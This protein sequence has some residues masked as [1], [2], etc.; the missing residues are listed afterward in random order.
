MKRQEVISLEVCAP[1]FKMMDFQVDENKFQWLK[2]KYLG[3]LGLDWTKD[4]NVD[5]GVLINFSFDPFDDFNL[6]LA[7]WQQ[8]G[9]ATLTHSSAFCRDVFGAN[10]F[11]LSSEKLVSFYHSPD[12]EH[13]I[14]LWD[15]C[16]LDQVE[17]KSNLSQKH[18]SAEELITCSQSLSS[19]LDKAIDSLN[20]Y[21]YTKSIEEL[22]LYDTLS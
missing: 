2:I 3:D 7:Q 19:Q 1:L 12:F 9:G 13:A 10:S 15:S 17:K 4:F 18:F 16:Q 14:K 21:E 6:S 5:D 22:F 8:R 11:K 20:T